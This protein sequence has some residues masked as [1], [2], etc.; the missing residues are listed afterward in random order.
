MFLSSPVRCKECLDKRINKRIERKKAKEQSRK[1][2][3]RT[4]F[5]RSKEPRMSIEDFAKMLYYKRQPA[6]LAMSKRLSDE[7]ITFEEQVPIG[8]FVVDFLIPERRL[9]IEVDGGY[10][11]SPE[12]KQKDANRSAFLGKRGLR[13]VRIENADVARCDLSS[14]ITLSPLPLPKPRL[15]KKANITQPPKSKKKTKKAKKQRVPPVRDF[16]CIRVP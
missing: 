4:V 15:V 13:V 10:H 12:Q 7:G 9:V 1:K 16:G 6:E 2:T 5:Q 3:A 11:D 8:P 14:L